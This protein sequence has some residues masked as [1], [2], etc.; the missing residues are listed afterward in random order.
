M[1]KLQL[2][3]V[4]Q[5]ELV[6]NWGLNRVRDDEHVFALMQ[7]MQD[8]GG[9]DERY[10]IGT[11]RID[12]K[13]HI[14]SGHHRFDAAFGSDLLF[15]LLPLDKVPVT[16][17]DG[18]FDALVKSMWDAHDEN[19][20]KKNPAFGLQLSKA[21]EKEQRLI[22]LS[23]PDIYILA[24]E[25]IGELWNVSR[26]TVERLRADFKE[27]LFKIASY[28]LNS[29]A[30]LAQYHFTPERLATMVELVKSGKRIGADGK[31]YYTQASEAKKEA[32]R[33]QLIEECRELITE[34]KACLT[35][36]CEKHEFQHFRPSYLQRRFYQHWELNHAQNVSRY[37]VPVLRKEISGHQEIVDILNLDSG[38][39]CAEFRKTHE[40]LH[41]C[42]RL[43]TET[44]LQIPDSAS[45]IDEVEFTKTTEWEELAQ[46]ERLN[47]LAAFV[48]T[49][50]TAL[51]NEHDAARE[52]QEQA[53]AA[54]AKEDIAE[55]AAIARKGTV[56][57]CGELVQAFK[58]YK[59]VLKDADYTAFITAACE[60]G[61]YSDEMALLP[62]DFLRPETSIFAS[63]RED[64]KHAHRIRD[65]ADRIRVEL[66]SQNP[67]DW[68]SPFLFDSQ[69][70]DKLASVSARWDTV[71]AAGIDDGWAGEG[72]LIVNAGTADILDAEIHAPYAGE[73]T[74]TD[75]E[76]QT[77]FF[78]VDGHRT[79]AMSATVVAEAE[80]Y[81][82]IK[83]QE[84]IRK[85]VIEAHQKRTE[86]VRVALETEV[87]PKR[88]PEVGMPEGG[89]TSIPPR[90]FRTAHAVYPALLSESGLFDGFT[91]ES[92]D[93]SEGLWRKVFADLGTT[94][95]TETAAWVDSYLEEVVATHRQRIEVTAR[96]DAL[97]KKGINYVHEGRLFKLKSKGEKGFFHKAFGPLTLEMEQ[98]MAAVAEDYLK[99]RE[100]A[101]TARTAFQECQAA[102]KAADD[103]LD[104][105]FAN[106][107]T[108]GLGDKKDDLKAHIR[109]ICIPPFS[110]DDSPLA[111]NATAG[112][113]TH[114]V[115]K[116]L[117]PQP[118]P[119]LLHELNLIDAVLHTYVS[120]EIWTGVARSKEWKDL[121]T[122]ITA[123]S[124]AKNIFSLTA[125]SETTEGRLQLRGQIENLQGRLDNFKAIE[126]AELQARA[127]K[128]SDASIHAMKT[129]AVE[130]SDALQTVI[131]DVRC[132]ASKVQT[133]KETLT[134]LLPNPTER[135]DALRVLLKW[136]SDELK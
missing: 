24:S 51:V 83:V 98:N 131:G 49:G 25:Q 71:R 53:A 39:W 5:K 68:M 121:R 3:Y 14:F 77:L 34:F 63:T 29:G 85:S 10:P 96:W 35:T 18:D 107:Q 123:S 114:F 120:S 22:Q 56:R 106:F 62:G 73:W 33:E 31:V 87:F 38:D 104:A 101:Q 80:T 17:I 93:I 23:F 116:Q 60:R 41:I 50:Y 119:N 16:V 81:L 40:V 89:L 115:E 136:T 8:F 100:N 127:D 48:D 1:S 47:R 52:A 132:P 6:P 7:H 129:A 54:Q 27:H 28:T 67:P 19:N 9:F 122:V 26:T 79:L 102:V 64:E 125:D 15:P 59:D 12:G 30:L 130:A 108:P 126:T 113:A 94:A 55:K 74:L 65:I 91:S 69:R 42:H 82:K 134:R 111:L 109:N 124:F 61:N 20:P 66:I 44:A 46:E 92:I 97:H 57:A 58:T 76:T 99:K 128:G 133:F 90:F 70:A 95:E 75:R 103:A 4:T 13:L 11:M 84:G 118:N 117:S 21:Q 86:Q 45:Y 88:I 43:R 110:E 78:R 105:V 112:I 36:F 135:L 72:Q 37:T 2:Q 32:A